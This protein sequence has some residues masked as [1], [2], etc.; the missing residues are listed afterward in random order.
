[1]A[2]TETH[3]LFQGWTQGFT[4]N[5]KEIM[6]WQMKTTQM[7]FDHAIKA[8]QTVSDFYQ[9]QAT[10][11]LK[12]TQACVMTGKTWAD[13]YRRHVLSATEKAQRTNGN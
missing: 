13:E 12:F 5:A 2:K 9:N 4:E 6:G 1:M 7:M 11:G 10:E 8:G 3:D